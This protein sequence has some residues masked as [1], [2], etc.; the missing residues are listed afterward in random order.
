[1]GERQ[2]IVGHVEKIEQPG[3][4]EAAAQ[5]AE[6]EVVQVEKES[7][8]EEPTE[9]GTTAGAETL[10]T[11]GKRR[12]KTQSV[13]AIE[14][15]A[16]AAKI[17]Q[18]EKLLKETTK[19]RR[20]TKEGLGDIDLEEAMEDTETGKTVPK[21]T[22]TMTMTTTTAMATVST[23]SSMVQATVE[24][25]AKPYTKLAESRGEH[26][27]ATWEKR[28]MWEKQMKER[29]EKENTEK[30]ARLQEIEEQ[31]EVVKRAL[32]EEEERKQHEIVKKL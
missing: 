32:L 21:T 30:A 9:K 2:K 16:T 29:Q 1:M 24:V 28:E 22:T 25:Y 19:W 18:Q 31:H 23:S 10:E 6:I 12:R 17:K 7:Q 15:A 5:V 11:D 13:A 26:S 20:A 3:A 8:L 14:K 4:E 27:S